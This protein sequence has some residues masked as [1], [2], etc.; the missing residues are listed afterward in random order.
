MGER[1]QAPP[2]SFL[3]P[4]GSGKGGSCGLA[5]VAVLSLNPSSADSPLSVDPLDGAVL[6]SPLLRG[7]LCA[8]FG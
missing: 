5:A 7:L 3:R 8:S 1:S 6:A 4:L 2:P